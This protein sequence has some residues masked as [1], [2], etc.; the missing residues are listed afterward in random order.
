MEY[1]NKK[2]LYVGNVQEI[3]WA[4]PDFKSNWPQGPHKG[5]FRATQFN[6]ISANKTLH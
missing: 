3:Y 6:H 4:E 1:F 5:Q 2:I